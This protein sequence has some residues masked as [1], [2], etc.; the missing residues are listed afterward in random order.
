[1]ECFA[2]RRRKHLR[3]LCLHSTPETGEMVAPRSDSKGH[4]LAFHQKVLDNA[5][6]SRYYYDNLSAES[7]C[8]LTHS[9]VR[10]FCVFHVPRMLLWWYLILLGSRCCRRR[11][12]ITPWRMPM[13]RCS[14]QP[15]IPAMSTKSYFIACW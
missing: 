2:F 9:R 3:L 10:G 14:T 4:D 7:L 12:P 15:G 8:H 5:L 11:S 6:P 1:M 13:T